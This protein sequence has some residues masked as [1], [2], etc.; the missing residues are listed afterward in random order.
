[1][2]VEP[3]GVFICS[4]PTGCGKSTTLACMI[5][6]INASASK[7]I[8]T[9]E[10]PIEYQFR[11]RRSLVSQREVGIDTASFKEGLRRVLRQDPDI[12][13]IGE[14]RD[15]ESFL[16]AMSMAETGHLIFT[17]THADTASQAVSRVLN[18]FPMEERG[19]M[20]MSLAANML[21]I[22]CQRLIPSGEGPVLP[23]V[24]VLINTPVVRKILH[25]GGLEKLPTAIETGGDQG[26]CSFNQCLHQMVKD[27]Q[28]DPETALEHSLNPEALVM[29]LEGID[30][31]I[32]RSIMSD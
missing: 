3:S 13:M 30:L 31:Q 5:D 27:G 8:I 29:A 17:T 25:E 26:M 15:A 4:G 32:D 22:M 16:A 2:A 7:R 20:R 6:Y 19:V 24:E 10:D 11:N 28:I 12:I 18:F 14:M 9:L 1:V 23:A 21:G